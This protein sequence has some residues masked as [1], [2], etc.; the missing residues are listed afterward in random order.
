[1][2]VYFQGYYCRKDDWSR[3]ISRDEAIARLSSE[4]SRVGIALAPASTPTLAIEWEPGEEGLDD[5]E[6]GS[7]YFVE[8]LDG[9][10]C[11]SGGDPDEALREA[12]RRLSERTTRR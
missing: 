12:E 6:E 11:S 1:M 7:T 5:P 9:T 8:A 2:F 10:F 4:E 3:T